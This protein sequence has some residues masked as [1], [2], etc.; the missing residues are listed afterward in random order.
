VHLVSIERQLRYSGELLDPC[1]RL[2]SLFFLAI[3]GLIHP[4]DLVWLFLSDAPNISHRRPQ[5][6]TQIQYAAPEASRFS[7]SDSATKEPNR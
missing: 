6:Q 7:V 3:C 4:H 1:V 5:S 2:P